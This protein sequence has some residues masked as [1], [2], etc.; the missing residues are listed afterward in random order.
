MSMQ[1]F[2]T[3]PTIAVADFTF[4]GSPPNNVIT[5]YASYGCSLFNPQVNGTVWITLDQ[6][7]QGNVDG[8]NASVD[9]YSAIVNYQMYGVIAGVGNWSCNIVYGSS[10]A[11]IA[12]GMAPNQVQL[13]FKNDGD[14]ANPTGPIKV[15]ILGC[16][17]AVV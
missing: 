6:I 15:W 4:S 12:L 8:V 3:D 5:T 2:G 11:G 1:A 9:A 17:Q 7:A 13:A 14:A 10:S 16:S